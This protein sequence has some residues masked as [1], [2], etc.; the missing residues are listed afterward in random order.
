MVGWGVYTVIAAS[1]IVQAF[2]LTH[3]K[4]VAWKNVIGIPAVF[5]SPIFGAAVPIL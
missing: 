3:W 4:A 2:G 5:G 1:A